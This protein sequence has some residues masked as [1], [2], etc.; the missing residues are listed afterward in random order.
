M[1][2]YSKQ[3]ASTAKA[4]Q[5]KGMSI[6][7][8]RVEESEEYDPA[9]DSYLTTETEFNTY[10]LRD[11]ASVKEVQGYGFTSGAA[12][13]YMSADVVNKVDTTDYVKFG[14]HKWNITNV[15]VTA[16]AEQPILFLLELKDS[17]EV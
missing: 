13:L 1:A 9:S 4:L 8:V 11:T 16:P 3:I 17:G 10:G 7:F 5:K 12:M 14:G 6:V 15:Q 2:D